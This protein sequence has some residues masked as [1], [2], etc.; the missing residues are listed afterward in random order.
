LAVAPMSNI[1]CFRYVDDSLDN[2]A[3][4]T[5]NARIRLMLL[6]EGKFYLVQTQLRGKHYL[7]T[8]LM[9][10]FTTLDDLEGLL[11]HIVNK[12]DAENKNRLLG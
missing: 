4:N 1:V 8:T 6:E 7:R 10:P 2:M 11:N 12:A 5:M 9:N 3:L